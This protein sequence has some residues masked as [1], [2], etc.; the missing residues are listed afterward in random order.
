MK[1]FLRTLG[2]ILLNCLMFG[3][4]LG[5]MTFAFLPKTAKIFIAVFRFVSR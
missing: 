1:R 3:F 5:R 4:T 2:N